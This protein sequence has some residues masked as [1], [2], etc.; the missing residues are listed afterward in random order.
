MSV[1]IISRKVDARTVTIKLVDGSLVNGKI[2]LHRSDVDIS[3]V[4]DLFTKVDDPFIVVFDATAEGKTGRVLI[5]NKRNIVWIAPEDE[6]RQK[7]KLRQEEEKPREPSGGS[8]LDRLR[9]T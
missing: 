1:S 2:N 6:A 8:L 3:R 4:S 7:E 5:L 9:S